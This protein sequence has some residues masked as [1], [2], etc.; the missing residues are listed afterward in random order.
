MMRGF[1]I[2]QESRRKSLDHF[3]DKKNKGWQMY[4]HLVMWR[5]KDK[6]S[7]E[8][9]PELAGEVKRR[10]DALPAII[11]EIRQYDIGL[12]IG[13]YGASFFDVGLISAFDTKADFEAYCRYPEHD[14]VVAFIQSVQ[15][16]EQ[17][18]DFEKA[19]SEKGVL[20]GAGDDIASRLRLG[21]AAR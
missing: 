18:V 11:K 21:V 3:T 1:G 14:E 16:D 9:R 17:I 13:D 10:L 5:L 20:A 6:A 8:S 19:R 2:T 7:G 12:N 4:I 15:E